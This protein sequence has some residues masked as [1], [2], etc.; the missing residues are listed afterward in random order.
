MID[1]IED[2]YNNPDS[3]IKWAREYN[4]KLMLHV[5]GVGLDKALEKINNYENDEQKIA[6]DKF[7]ISNKF[8]TDRL[9]RPA[10]N[11]FSAKGGFSKFIFTS[12]G[13][14]KLENEFKDKLL[15]VHSGYT[16]SQYIEK[17]WF[18]KYITDPNGLIFLEVS[19]DGKKIYPTYK[20]ISSIRNYKQDGIRPD[21]VIFEPDTTIF[22]EEKRSTIKEELFWAVDG[23]GYYRY[24]NVKNGEAKGITLVDTKTHLFKHVPA[25]LCSDTEDPVTGWKRSQIDQ[26]VE[27]LNK[28]M[29][30]NSV[31]N[32]VEFFHNYP[33]P[34]EYE[35][36]CPRCHGTGE[37]AAR[38]TGRGLDTTCPRCSG[39]GI[40]TRKDP[41]DKLR[42]KPPVEG[43][44]SMIPPGG[45]ITLPPEAWKLKTNSV[46]RT[47]DMIM[48]SQWG[49]VMEYGSQ[50]GNQ[51]AT[52]TGRWTDTQP[53]NN[54]LNKYTASA[55]LI[56][57][58]IAD[59]FGTFYFSLTFIKS[60]IVY[61]RRY[62]IETP[63]QLMKRYT[64]LGNLTDN[65][66]VMDITCDQ[67]LE[68]EFKDNDQLYVYN[69]KIMSLDPF[70]HFNIAD[71]KDFA[72]VSD[73]KK[74]LY[75]IDFK[76]TMSEMEVIKMDQAE[77]I[78]KYEQYIS[79]KGE[80]Q[81]IKTAP[82]EQNINNNQN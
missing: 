59:L 71:I 78:K 2:K 35:D 69:K 3:R 67:Y 65:S 33:L 68:S 22:D 15:D 46:D 51:Y 1:N 12:D 81:Q 28:Y 74:K 14:L 62:L 34:W 54:K 49:A 9:L 52:A 4:D 36:D 18:D 76:N 48:F 29:V 50:Q 38:D 5:H 47:W 44:S 80:M 75:V 24:K 32:I 26:Q 7:A 73:L 63:D 37:V 25:I 13:D 53:V 64:E 11:I 55:Q 57:N 41:T 79:T 21:W 45:Y 70:P 8:I 6:R 42:I 17:V 43:E 82:V 77:L 20:S 58:A 56:H 60:M 31:L 72:P 39:T 27:L 30:D 23:V 19:E 10:D 40:A 16:L 61:G 66:L